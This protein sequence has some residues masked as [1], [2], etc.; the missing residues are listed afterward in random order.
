VV[1]P[2]DKEHATGEK[3]CKTL[4]EWEPQ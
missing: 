1:C 3:P 2:R 4:I